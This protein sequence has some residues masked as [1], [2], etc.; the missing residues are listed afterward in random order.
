MRSVRIEVANESGVAVDETALSQL[1][2]VR[3][4]PAA[5]PPARRAVACC[6]STSRRWTELHVQWM[7]EPGPTD[8]LAFPMDELRGPAT[9]R[10]PPEGLLGDVVLCPAV[11]E[12]Q[13]RDAGHGTADELHLLYRARD[14]APARLRPR[15]AGRGARDVRAPDATCWSGGARTGAAGARRDD[16]RVRRAGCCCWRSS[17]SR[18]PPSRRRPTRRSRRVSRVAVEAAVREGRRGAEP[19]RLVV[20]DPARYVNVVLF[21]Q[22]LCEVAATVAVASVA[23]RRVLRAVDRAAHGL[24]VMVVVT[25]VAGRRGAAHARPPARRAG[26]ARRRPARCAPWPGCSSR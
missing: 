20:A 17:W 6:W 13:A 8:V 10:S 16:R 15:R 19:L 18:G 23:A 4:G 1:R 5:G 25:Y 21:L 26:R 14:P 11:A 3:A 12:R 22:V 7:D 24:G 9:T 2:G